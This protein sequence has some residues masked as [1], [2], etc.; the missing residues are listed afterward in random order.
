MHHAIPRVPIH[1]RAHSNGDASENASQASVAGD[2]L[3]LR[4]ITQLVGVSK[5][6]GRKHRSV[7]VWAKQRLEGGKTLQSGGAT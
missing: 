2:Q 5:Q 3:V 7:S 6:R 1:L 4:P